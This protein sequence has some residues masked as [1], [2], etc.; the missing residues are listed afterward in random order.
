LGATILEHLKR[1]YIA[2]QQTTNLTTIMK[3]TLV[4]LGLF[5]A[6][7]F[8]F[9]CTE[10]LGK[11]DDNIKLSQKKANFKAE[12]DSIIITTEGEWW[13]ITDISFNGNRNYDLSNIDV[14]S[15]NYT[16]VEPEFK[17]ERKNTKTIYIEMEENN[18]DSIRILKIGLE[19]GDYFDGITITQAT[20]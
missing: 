3:K 18:K 2:I 20:K 17:I 16:I 6:L 12:K 14:T 1:S 13:W 19:A 8:T 10:P 7:F 15:T 9:S 5:I 4:I 11:W